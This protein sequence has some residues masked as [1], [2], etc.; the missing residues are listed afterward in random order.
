MNY[1][2]AN[3][4]QL[5]FEQG[6]IRDRDIEDKFKQLRELVKD[7]DREILIMLVDNT[8]VVKHNRNL[9]LDKK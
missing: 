6:Y 8:R 5:Q 3:G 4:C 7:V 2:K 9:E 1:V